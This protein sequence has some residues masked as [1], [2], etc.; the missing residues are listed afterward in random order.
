[1]RRLMPTPPIAQPFVRVEHGEAAG[2][3]SL[4]ITGAGRPGAP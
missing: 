2:T 3:E 1:M 4:L